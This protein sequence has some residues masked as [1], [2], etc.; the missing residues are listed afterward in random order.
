MNWI[1]PALAC[2]PRVWCPRA[3]AIGWH[4]SSAVVGTRA[5]E[6]EFQVS[7][8]DEAG[9]LREAENGVSRTAIAQ[10][11]SSGNFNLDDKLSEIEEAYIETALDACNGNFSQA[12]RM[13]G[14]N[15]TTLYSRLN[16]R[17]KGN[18]GHV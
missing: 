6:A 18:T 11:L 1:R 13:L 4:C 3:T 2:S 10:D 7:G 9:P 8:V 12:A 15:R 16:K 5:L 17:G 14:V